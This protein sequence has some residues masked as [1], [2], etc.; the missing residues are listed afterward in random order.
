M[1]AL[2]EILFYEKRTDAK[3]PCI[4]TDGLQMVLCNDEF[5][6]VVD[7]QCKTETYTFTTDH[8]TIR[9]L[10]LSRKTL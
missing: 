3:N 7:I 6:S 4:P 2:S 8:C 5:N 9:F 10:I 1:T